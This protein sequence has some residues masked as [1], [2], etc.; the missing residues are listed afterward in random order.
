MSV[1]PSTALPDRLAPIETPWHV[2]FGAWVAESRAHRVIC[3][4]L[5]I[6]LLNAFDLALTLL[7]H[8]QGVLDEENP[9]ARMLLGMGTPSIVLFK[10][11]LVLIG[12]HPLLRYRH[13]RVTELG[14]LVILVAY[15]LLAVHW[16]ECYKLY[17][18]QMSSEIHMAE[19]SIITGVGP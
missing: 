12:T 17:T 3:L 16:Q 15:A 6:W 19:M 4:V 10:I 2:R 5:G 8:S 13:A 18:L 14:T 1:C 11:G 7:A 9:L